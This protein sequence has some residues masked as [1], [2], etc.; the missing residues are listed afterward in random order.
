[1]L[2][3][4]VREV[5]AARK[6]ESDVWAVGHG[7]GGALAQLLQ[8]VLLAADVLPVSIRRSAQTLGTVPNAPFAL[9]R[10]PFQQLSTARRKSSV[11][12]LQTSL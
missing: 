1:M 7:V 12:I 9:C 10:C 4:I 2:P 5:Q 6:Y 3:V 11:L 8:L